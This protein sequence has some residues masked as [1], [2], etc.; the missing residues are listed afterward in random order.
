MPKR[1]KIAIISLFSAILMLPAFAVNAPVQ[2]S[3]A[4]LSQLYTS[5]VIRVPQ[6]FPTIQEAIQNADP[7]N[8]IEVDS[9][10]GPYLGPIEINKSLVLS[11]VN[12]RA[13]IEHVNR[14]ASVITITSGL[15]QIHGFEV[16]GGLA[17]IFLDKSTENTVKDNMLK[18]NF[19]GVMLLGSENNMVEENTVED[20]VYGIWLIDSTENRLEKNTARKNTTAGIQLGG[21]SDNN[22]VRSNTVEDNTLG[23]VLVGG[24]SGNKVE[25]NIAQG[26]S[27]AG[28]QV[29]DSNGNVVQQNTL[30]HNGT[31]IAIV[32]S[33]GNRVEG[34]AI[35]GRSFNG[36]QLVNSRD[37]ILK[38]NTI[39]NGQFGI[40]ALGSDGNYIEK[41]EVINNSFGIQLTDSSTNVLEHNVVMSQKSDGIILERSSEN[42]ILRNNTVES[43]QKFGIRIDNSRGNLLEDNIFKRNV[44]GGIL[45][46]RSSAENIVRNNK[47]E[48]NT[49]AFGITI[50]DSNGNLLE[51]N[52]TTS[53]EIGIQLRNA[54]ENTLDG[55][56]AQ[57]NTFVGIE[58]KNSAR[59]RLTNNVTMDNGDGFL[60]KDSDDNVLTA[61]RAE[62][63]DVGFTLN[64]SDR[65]IL[66]T[67]EARNNAIGFDV[68]EG[69]DN[70]LRANIAEGNKIGI[71]VDNSNRTMLDDNTAVNNSVAN[72]K[73]LDL[74]EG[75][76]LVRFKEGVSQ[77]LIDIVIKRQ[78][79]KVI[80]FFPL[81]RIFHLCI[82]DLDSPDE[83]KKRATPKETL[84]KVDDFKGEGQVDISEPNVRFQIA[85]ARALGSPNDPGFQEQWNLVQ[86]GMPKAWAAGYTGNSNVQV[87]I[88]DSGV[89]F[90]TPQDPK[91]LSPHPD[92]RQNLDPDFR[93]DFIRNSPVPQDNLGHGTFVMGIIAAEG[94]NGTGI[95]GVN[96]HASLISLKVADERSF[97]EEVITLLQSLFIGKVDE[98]K[99]LAALETVIAIKICDSGDVVAFNA[100]EDQTKV[101]S[102]LCNGNGEVLRQVPQEILAAIQKR[103]A[104]RRLHVI[105]FSASINFD[106]NS[107]ENFRQA[108]EKAGE[109]N[110]LFIT[111]AGNQGEDV[112]EV[113]KEGKRVNEVLPC[114]FDLDN[115]ICV[116]ASSTDDKLW[117]FSNYG[118]A[119]VD[120]LAP[121]E[122]IV[123]T[124]P[125]TE[126]TLP[127]LL[128]SC[129]RV[130]FLIEFIGKCDGTSFATAHVSGVAALLFAI[131]PG[132]SAEEIKDIILN[133]VEEIEELRGKVVSSGRLK[134]PDE[135][136]L[137]EGGCQSAPLNVEQTRSNSRV[138]RAEQ[139]PPWSSFFLRE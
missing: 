10:Q 40:S 29:Q 133:S 35:S 33:S 94:N 119:S 5:T 49:S 44:Q 102:N 58:L 61:N 27:A 106:A 69:E 82:V 122:I 117:S 72:T 7:G 57:G 112:D 77:Q 53:N 47:S 41:N 54:K 21:A 128:E 24:S 11:S 50:E 127:P 42:N 3:I 15:V 59:N 139:H 34:N 6:D 130:S 129:Q 100:L 83:C 135:E 105:N 108:I 114:G 116:G 125:Q 84:S 115:I 93:Y 101:P 78:S 126:I 131:C 88:L 45:I 113:S 31:G 23:I 67:N 46:Q 134:W 8:I 52:L 25:T 109:H 30:Q 20:N 79:T 90:A 32:G 124:I 9:T 103:G 80:R 95:A 110:L 87:A 89:D 75:E 92:L 99:I 55:N 4:S 68:R 36:I 85:N 107:L 1:T 51:T 81:F 37:N 16:R 120:L 74:V 12:G 56:R 39:E 76:L 121:G 2:W 98:D 14:M 65:N 86:I 38:A 138:A 71:L 118:Q 137:R 43:N 60:L 13:I 136:K 66:E 19:A 91:D 132:K 104:Q 64:R 123:S 18:N 62:Q 97:S 63:E 73:L 26:N 28:I 22:E 70:V 48:S 96:W 111:A 17:G